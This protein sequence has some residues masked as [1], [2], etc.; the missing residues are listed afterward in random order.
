MGRS[1]HLARGVMAR[2]H[3]EMFRRPPVDPGITRDDVN[4]IMVKLMMMD[5]KL[6][7][8]LEVFDGGG[9]G[10]DEED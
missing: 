3:G 5:D 2:H 8:I 9:G 7:D 4:A 10:E 1:G 6:D